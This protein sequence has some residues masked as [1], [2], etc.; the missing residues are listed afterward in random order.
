MPLYWPQLELRMARASAERRGLR[1]L[2]SRNE[3]S[4][5]V[6]YNNGKPSTEK[7]CLAGAEP[8]PALWKRKSIS[9]SK[10]CP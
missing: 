5:L 8:M 3:L 7:S 6:A 10:R 2:V 1:R 4:K 9:M